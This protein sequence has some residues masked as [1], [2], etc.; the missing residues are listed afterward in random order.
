MNAAEHPPGDEMLRVVIVDD[1]EL[2]RM[3]LARLLGREEGVAIVAEA[4]SG[5]EA[6]EVVR[7][8]DPDLLLLDVRM[9]DLD[10]FAV[11]RELRDDFFGHVVFVTAYDEHAV[12][13]FEVQA[14]DY[15]VK[16]VA[17]D[18]LHAA[19][20]RAR[21][22]RERRD[23]AR[24]GEAAVERFLV[25]IGDRSVVVK[26]SDVDWFE[27]EANY[28][29]L[30]V[31]RQSYLMRATMSGL[32]RALDASRFVRIHRTTIVNID[33]V[34]E[35]APWFSGDHVVLLGDGSK[36]RMSRS[37]AGRLLAR[38]RPG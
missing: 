35:I 27:A 31:G 1:E 11:L 8:E 17:P 26:A 14:L 10:G 19:L 12:R 13:A 30:R 20:A 29:R 15:L 28:V 23:T 25:K 4:A 6:V 21:S 38:M 32:E 16:P 37:Y 18:R 7:R 36:L 9:P 24:R 33:R 22:A 3:R 2:A 34:K 5:T